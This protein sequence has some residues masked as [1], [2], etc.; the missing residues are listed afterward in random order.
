MKILL[1]NLILIEY[2]GLLCSVFH[3]MET[4]HIMTAHCVTILLDVVK[5][6]FYKL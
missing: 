4:L 5:K 6:D 1:K 3:I 2:K